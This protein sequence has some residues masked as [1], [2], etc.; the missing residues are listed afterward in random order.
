LTETVEAFASIFGGES[1]AGRSAAYGA[2]ATGRQVVDTVSSV[3]NFVSGTSDTVGDLFQDLTRDSADVFTA[4]SRFFDDLTTNL[5]NMYT[6]GGVQVI[7][8][9]KIMIK[10]LNDNERSP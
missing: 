8:I 9:N 3:S 7:L 6:S 10:R 5:R 1:A 4:F 2:V